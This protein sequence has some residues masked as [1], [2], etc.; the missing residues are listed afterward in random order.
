VNNIDFGL[1]SIITPSYNAAKFIANTIESVTNQSYNNWELIIVDDCSTD[2]TTDIVKSYLEKDSRIRLIMLDNNSGA[3]ARPRNIGISQ[4][5]GKWIALLDSD[6]IWHP[7]KLERQ[8]K[9]MHDFAARFSCTQMSD[10]YDD[11][12][13]SFSS[14][15][16]IGCENISFRMQQLK[17][18]IPTSSVI[19]DK[20]LALK[21][22]FNEDQRYKAVEDYHCWLRILEETKGCIKLK[23]PLLYYRRVDGQISSS[24]TYMFK[25]IFMVHNEYPG[26]SAIKATLLTFTHILGGI[27]FRMIMKGL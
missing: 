1:V 22:T 4:A 25:R 20:I 23:Y 16:A 8:L 2:N 24:K 14:P 18:R 9:T 11:K 7:E 15:G 12:S 27:Y 6:D 5:S 17:G 19:V 13:I 26:G 3:P 21:H 10:F